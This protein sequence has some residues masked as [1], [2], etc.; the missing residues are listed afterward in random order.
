MI[1]VTLVVTLASAMVWQQWRAVE[2]EAAERARAQSAWILAGALDWSRLI[3]K[4]DGRN[5]DRPTA[6]TEPWAVP[7]AE[8]RLST[9]LAADAANTDDGP[10]AFLSGTITD[11][12]SRYN[13]RNLIVATPPAV[14]PGAPTLAVGDINPLEL[15]VLAQLCESV[16]VSSEV[17]TR[18]ANGLRDALWP[19]GRPGAP[20]NP[21][22]L[23]QSVS[24]LT[25][26][27]IDDATV[28]RLQPYVT[29]LTSGAQ[30]PQPAV[31]NLNTA[32][33][34]VLVTVIPQMDRGRA[35]Q[36]VQV[37]QRTPFKT[38]TDAAAYLPT[39]PDLTRLTV[40]SNFFEVRGRLRLGDRVLQER[41]LVERM[42]PG[43]AMTVVARQRERVSSFE[44]GP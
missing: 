1:I 36:L 30:P 38:L 41:S 29:L 16:G 3:L 37:R 24:Q 9:F 25:W 20:A 18:I 12:Q 4:E 14:T 22:L 26:L 21:P 35:E 43:A 15:A 27:G 33:V 44:Q 17:A 28:K 13:L 34:E 23:P 10:E 7:L 11:A 42:G 5:A 31:L 40:R 2:V 39:N 6:L 32:P 19:S 8:A